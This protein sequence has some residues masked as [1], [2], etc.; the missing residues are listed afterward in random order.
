VCVDVFQLD[1]IMT[2]QTVHSCCR[3]QSEAAE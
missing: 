1:L 3:P 2:G